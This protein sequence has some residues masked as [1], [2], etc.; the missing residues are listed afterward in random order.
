MTAMLFFAVLGL[1]FI[2]SYLWSP[3]GLI[4]AGVMV[5]LSLAS[6]FIPEGNPPKVGGTGGQGNARR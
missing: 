3:L 4:L 1:L 2:G 6:A 5:L